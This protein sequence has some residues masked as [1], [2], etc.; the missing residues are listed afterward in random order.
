MQRTRL[1]LV[2]AGA[3][4]PAVAYAQ[5]PELR[6]APE[7]VIE[8]GAG[9]TQLGRYS[10]V[11]VDRSG[12]FFVATGQWDGE[13]IGFDSTGKALGWRVPVGRRS[14]RDIGWI[15]SWGF[16]GDSVWIYDRMYDQLVIL[17]DSGKIERSIER[18]TW[19]RPG[20]GDRR[21]YPLFSGLEWVASYGDGTVLVRPGRR[22]AIFDAPEY[23]RSA[24][25]LLRATDDG[26][27]LRTIAKLPAHATEL[28][29]NFSMPVV[30]RDGVERKSFQV[31]FVARTAYR[32]SHDGQRI[33]IA[34]ASKT[35][36]GVVRVIM[37]NAE[38]D[39]LFA[40]QYTSEAT[41]L[42][43]EQVEQRLSGV[44]PFGK[45]S[46][47]W[48]KDTLRKNIPAFDSRLMQVQIGLDHSTWIWFRQGVPGA[49]ALVLDA[50][51]N[52]VGWATFPPGA[53]LTALSLDRIWAIETDPKSRIRD[54]AVLVRLKRQP[55]TTSNRTYRGKR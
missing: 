16:A 48:I 37:L 46:A 43:K 15:D 41:R 50:R 47:D 24:L 4:F 54:A 6:F 40:R 32:V 29:S 14:N 26:R 5:I 21:K 22:R 20:W 12:R 44:T 19:L 10:Q 13:L 51:G 27:I 17:G 39:T 33:A 42:T 25:H 53:R 38:G 1:T 49:R 3:I 8:L 28:P 31:P 9:K 23:D 34:E 30:L 52:P 2:L 11:L 18:P 7:R 55:Q 36:S 45:Y 35:D